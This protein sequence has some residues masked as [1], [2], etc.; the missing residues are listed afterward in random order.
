MKWFFIYF[1]FLKYYNTHT[2]THTLNIH[3]LAWLTGSSIGMLGWADLNP[4]DPFL[5]FLWA[6]VGPKWFG[7]GPHGCWP[8]PPTMLINYAACRTNSHSACSNLVA[9]MEGRRYLT[10][11]CQIGGLDG[12]DREGLTWGR[13]LKLLQRWWP[14][15]V[16]GGG[17][18]IILQKWREGGA[19]A[20]QGM[21]EAYWRSHWWCV[22]DLVA[23]RL[24]VAP[25]GGWDDGEREKN[26]ERCRLGRKTNAEG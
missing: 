13:W 23:D 2:H 4:I 5:F 22:V 18:R 24:V 14:V 12:R 26:R 1:V 17:R 8:N 25:V 3:R 21:V 7:P 10:L 16:V 11:E 6:G 20:V 19:A 9:A 15:L